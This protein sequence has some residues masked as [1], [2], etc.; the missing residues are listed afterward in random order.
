MP[1]TVLGTGDAVMKKRDKNPGSQGF[2]SWMDLR[3]QFI[4][5]LSIVLA[6]SRCSI[7]TSNCSGEKH[8]IHQ[9]KNCNSGLEFASVLNA[10]HRRVGCRAAAVQQMAAAADTSHSGPGSWPRGG[11]MGWRMQRLS[12]LSSGSQWKA[13]SFW[14][15]SLKTELLILSWHLLLCPFKSS[16][17]TPWG[18]ETKLLA[19]QDKPE[20][21]AAELWAGRDKRI[22][23][24]QVCTIQ[25]SPGRVV[26]HTFHSSSWFPETSG[27]LTPTAGT[28]QL[29]WPWGD[30]IYFSKLSAAC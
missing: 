26:G 9:D 24:S 20:V 11:G 15:V 16:H 29:S 27:T 3:R 30:T 22:H 21:S 14:E 1:G 8:Y 13:C 19:L 18:R 5:V 17:L 25:G 12:F 7:N 2:L 23:G 28:S 4:K 10:T 6:L